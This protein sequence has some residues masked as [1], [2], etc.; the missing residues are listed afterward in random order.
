MNHKKQFIDWG[1]G[2]PNRG[3]WIIIY[4]QPRWV[5]VDFMSHIKGLYFMILSWENLLSVDGV[6]IL[7]YDL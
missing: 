6:Y 1:L 3:F 2:W 7:V 5:A 4:E